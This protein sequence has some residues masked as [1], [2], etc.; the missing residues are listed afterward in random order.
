[1]KQNKGLCSQDM[2]N[3]L[4][5]ASQHIVRISYGVGYTRNKNSVRRDQCGLQLTKKIFI[6]KIRLTMENSVEIT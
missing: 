2:P 1:M 4:G 5:R 6:K 3:L